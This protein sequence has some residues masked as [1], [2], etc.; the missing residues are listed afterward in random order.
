MT[1]EKILDYSVKFGVLPF[2]IYMIW[3]TRQDLTEVKEQLRNCYEERIED[4]RPYRLQS[5][6]WEWQPIYVIIPEKT[7]YRFKSHTYDV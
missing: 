2:M 4:L 6:V 3:I 1:P 7:K 5:D